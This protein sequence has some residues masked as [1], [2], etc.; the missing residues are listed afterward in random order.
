MNDIFHYHSIEEYYKAIL[1]ELRLVANRKKI[2]LNRKWIKQFDKLKGVYI[3]FENDELK[4]VGETG[5][6]AGRMA[7]LL[8]TKNHTIRRSIG[9]RNFSK[10]KGYQKASAKQSYIPAIEKKLNKYIES[11]L[12]VSCM[13][14]DIGRKEFEEWVIERYPNNSFYNKRKK[15]K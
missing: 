6:L 11:K 8:N 5:N 3:I 1:K 14:L 15:R 12:S 7:D 9:E 2:I 13:P 4:Y 10:V